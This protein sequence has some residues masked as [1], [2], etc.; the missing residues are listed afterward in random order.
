MDAYLRAV[1]ESFGDISGIAVSDYNDDT[2]R[3]AR[4]AH[5]EFV[6]RSACSAALGASDEDYVGVGAT[7]AEI[8]GLGGRCA[9]KTGSALHAEYPMADVADVDELRETINAELQEFEEN[10]EVCDAVYYCL[11]CGHVISC[12]VLPSPVLTCSGCAAAYV[13]CFHVMYPNTRTTHTTHH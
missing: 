7:V 5:V 6:K 8:H 4:F 12:P 1:F 3:N 11:R 10:E 2:S 9:P 13:V